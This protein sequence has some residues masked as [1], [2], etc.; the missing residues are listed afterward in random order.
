MEIIRMESYNESVEFFSEAVFADGKKSVEPVLDAIT[1]IKDQLEEELKS[2]DTNP[3]KFDPKKYWKSLDW[4]NLEDS[5]M[6]VFGFRYCE[7]N[8]YVEKYMGK[9]VFES[10][11]LNCMV[12]HADRFPIEG[13]VTDKGFYDKSHSTTMNIYISLGLIHVLDPD[14][15]LAVLLHEFGHSIDPALTTITY[16]ETNI[17]SK[18]I[19]DRKGDLTKT[20]KKIVEEDKKNLFGAATGLVA[21][22]VSKV[23]SGSSLLL[24]VIFGGSEKGRLK[25]IKKALDKEKGEFNRK[26]C[27]EAF[28]DNFARMYGYG[29][30]V[31]RA[32]HKVDKQNEEEMNSWI[33]R[34]RARQECIT[35]LTINAINDVHKTD[36]H[37]IRALIKEYKE[38]ISDPNTPPKVKKALEEDMGELEK[39]LDMYLNNFSQFQNN[40]NK[41]INEELERRESSSEEA[42][43]S[44]TSKSK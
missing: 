11:E 4:K 36:I 32:L 29:A 2:A 1:K 21:T 23:K 31:M 41:L 9:N 22:L 14:E 38:D 35:K 7:V 16:T 12:Y 30:I 39:V 44:D 5:I 15:I 10:K 24:D 8:P 34:E 6:K 3:K 13:L 40:V 26:E 27:S 25:K 33:K 37:R 18:Y 19:T 43:T 17:L 28:A 42:K 20:E